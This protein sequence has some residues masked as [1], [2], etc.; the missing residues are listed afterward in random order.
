[1][2]THYDLTLLPDS[3]F[4]AIIEE[5]SRKVLPQLQ[6][7]VDLIV[8][9]PP[10]ADAR[11]KHYDSIHPDDFVN[12]FLTFHSSLWDSLKPSGSLVINI[13][14]KVINGVRH[15]FVWHLIDSLSQLGW[16]CIDEEMDGNI[17][18]IWPNAKSRL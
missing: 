10:Y 12:W 1:M 18:F 9:S 7:C 8:T 13:K 4:C 2:K 14:D 16:Q 17:V 15:R 3:P 5:D 6:N 11:S